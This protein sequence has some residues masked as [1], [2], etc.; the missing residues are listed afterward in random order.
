MYVSIIISII[1]LILSF[2]TFIYNIKT[3]QQEKRINILLKS[4]ALLVSYEKSRDNILE[5]YSNSIYP[6]ELFFDELTDNEYCYDLFDVIYKPV[7]DPWRK[8]FFSFYRKLI[9]DAW[10][11]DIIFRRKHNRYLKFFLENY[12]ELLYVIYQYKWN[13]DNYEKKVKEDTSK[14]MEWNFESVQKSIY[15]TNLKEQI[16]KIEDSY[17]KLKENDTI[18]ELKNKTRLIM[19]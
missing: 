3:S 19:P 7:K 5:D 17:Q 8:T 15:Q 13:M 2:F 10:L 1:A 18:N 6:Y 4:Q 11:C 14:E 9:E 16:K 12:G